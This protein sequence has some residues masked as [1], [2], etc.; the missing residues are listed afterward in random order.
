MTIQPKTEKVSRTVLFNFVSVSEIF[1]EGLVLSERRSN[2]Y[3]GALK[4]QL[5]KGHE[6]SL[7]QN[8]YNL[9]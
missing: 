9:Q 1:L 4:L 5:M 2:R 8:Y 7:S 6:D 3:T